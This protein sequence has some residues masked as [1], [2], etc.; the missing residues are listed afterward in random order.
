MKRL[1]ALTLAVLLCFGMTGT[2]WA[3]AEG[4][5]VTVSSG[6]A[7]PGETVT[8]TVSIAGAENAVSI[9]MVPAYDT[10]KLELLSGTWLLTGATLADDWSAAFGDAVITF[11]VD[12]DL[13]K[14]V[15]QMEFRVK[16]GASGTASVT[17]N[18][19]IQ[20]T[21][22][23]AG[24]SLPVTEVPG[25]VTISAG[26]T[27]PEKF[28]KPMALAA[29]DEIADGKTSGDSFGIAGVQLRQV[30]PAGVRYLARMS[31]ALLA[32]LEAQFGEGNVSYG[33]LLQ[34]GD[35][36][37]G[38]DDLTEADVDGRSIAEGGAVFCP[39]EKQFAVLDD[40]FYYTAVVTGVPE[41]FDA[42]KIIAR[43]YVKCGDVYYFATEEPSAS[44]E[45]PGAAAR[46]GG[47]NVSLKQVADYLNFDLSQLKTNQ[48]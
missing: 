15:F 24:E 25:T 28:V 20:K 32:E 1:I 40:Y 22:H 19:V 10:E 47:Y 14:D 31:N 46:S 34:R 33:F 43:A 35:P 6:S 2:L 7:A 9:A 3:E 44:Y 23:S 16:D 18:P 38:D 27:I 26:E 4:A 17:C 36:D 37:F 21:S 5:V 42:S 29:N 11:A 41:D 8:L 39:G 12:T 45:V 13:N 30:A 48:D